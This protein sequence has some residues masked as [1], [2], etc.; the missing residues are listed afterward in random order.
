[1]AII[2][3]DLRDL[4]AIEKGLSKDR[5]EFYK[6]LSKDGLLEEI[7]KKPIISEWTESQGQIFLEIADGC[8]RAK[9]LFHLGLTTIPIEAVNDNSE[10]ARDIDI[11]LKLLS[12]KELNLQEY[13]KYLRSMNMKPWKH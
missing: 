5:V 10:L 7:N 6:G 9:A 2:Q 12:L 8:H 4:Y 3:Y 13:E 11:P 1:M